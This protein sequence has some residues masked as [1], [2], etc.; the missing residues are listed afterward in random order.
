MEVKVGDF[1]VGRVLGPET[2]MV[3]T[4]YGT[5]LVT[6]Y[7]WKRVAVSVSV[8]PFV[9]VCPCPCPCQRPRDSPRDRETDRDGKYLS[10]ELCENK[11]YNHKTDM[12]SLGVLL[13]ELLALR[14]P[15]GG[16][17]LVELARFVPA[18]PS[19]VLT[20]SWYQDAKS[21]T[22]LQRLAY[23]L[24]RPLRHVRLITSTNFEP[25]PA[26]VSALASKAVALLLQR[27]QE[28]RP[29]AKQ[30]CIITAGKSEHEQPHSW[31]K[32]RRE[33]ALSPIALLNAARLKCSVG[34]LTDPGVWG[35]QDRVG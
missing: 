1:G 9:S 28:K 34:G 15:F 2:N 16:R 27:E 17:N 8:F 32:L 18:A 22:D 11:P 13:Y 3:E 6:L 14:P 4:M 12:W 24:M 5:P 33:G 10:P 26:H 23:Q 21:D 7:V 29:T 35:Y 25:L 19:P 30:V 31:Y 20:P